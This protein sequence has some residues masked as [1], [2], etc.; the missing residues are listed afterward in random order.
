M[1]GLIT[2]KS[3]NQDFAALLENLLFPMLG[4]KSSMADY[5]Q[6]YTEDDAPI[7]MTAGVLS[8]ETY[9]V[10]TTAADMIRFVEANMNMI[11][12]GRKLARNDLRRDAGY[13]NNAAARP[14][15]RCFDRQ[16][17]IDERLRC[18][19][20]FHSG[21]ANRDRSSSQ[22]ELPHRGPS[23]GSSSDTDATRRR[24]TLTLLRARVVNPCVSPGA[25]RQGPSDIIR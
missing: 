13:P 5:A 9:G 19:C 2:A 18:I 7:R 21:K 16:N 4:M 14:S 24:T 15:E 23:N 11:A 17:R 1:L 3:M 22:Q 20:G 25:A 10:R 6:G 12:T 8:S